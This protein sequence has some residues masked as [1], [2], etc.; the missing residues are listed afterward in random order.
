MPNGDL[1]KAI[2]LSR[3][4]ESL[5][6]LKKQESLEK[7]R[8]EIK[9]KYRALNRKDI[10]IDEKRISQLMANEEEKRNKLTRKQRTELY[11]DLA[12]IE[13][14]HLKKFTLN[15]KAIAN[16][17]TTSLIDI[18]KTS[19][20]KTTSGV[21]QYISSYSNYMSQIDARLQ[22]STKSF[23]EIADVIRGNVGISPYVKQTD[24]LKKIDEAVD[25]GIAYN[26]EQRAFLATVSKDIA[27]TF[28]AF[29]SNLSRII[30]IQ[31]A[32]ST[33]ARLGLEAQL[34]QFFNN[35]FGDTSYLSNLFDTVSANLLSAQALLGKKE[36]VSFEYNVQK[37]LGSLSSV[38]VS[39]S[40]I[41]SL[42]Q[43]IGYLA[44]GNISQLTSNTQMQSLLAI[45]SQYAGLDYGTFFERG[46][47]A[48]DVNKLL[49]GITTFAQTINQQQS[50]AARSK[51]AETFGLDITD[52]V[53]LTNL[54]TK[55]L[56]TISNNI[57][58]YQQ[59]ENETQ[60]QLGL[61]GGRLSV[62][63]QIQNVFD[64]VMAGIGEN[65]AGSA[66]QY[67]T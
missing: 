62:A 63:Q 56:T 40:T 36:S 60:R 11:N 23:R 18:G 65:I 55:D 13:E 54:S 12:K 19:L 59:A 34:T 58:T 47:S 26:V 10:E 32:D 50:L 15:M 29:N 35:T 7:R 53:A 44:S 5:D 28:D 30:K 22:G 41:S 1:K 6:I 33:A 16:A 48:E 51:L 67:G 37:W 14:N 61:L 2:Q 17:V 57:L 25:K 66:L 52:L 43:A 64:N 8:N 21:E 31:Q 38:G 49:K 9:E 42:S 24:I 3:G 4:Q 27:T 20:N 46:A 45:A 39:D